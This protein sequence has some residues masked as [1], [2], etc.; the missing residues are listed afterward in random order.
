MVSILDGDI[1]RTHLSSERFS[2]KH[3]SIN[4]RRMVL[5]LERLQKTVALLCAHQFAPRVRQDLQQKIDFKIWR[6][7][8]STC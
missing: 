4:V 2:K 7:Y 6:L 1:T 8:R 3:R 5:L